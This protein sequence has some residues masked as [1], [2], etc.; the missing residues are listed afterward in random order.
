[1]TIREIR[2]VGDPVLRTPTDPVRQFDKRLRQLAEDMFETMYDAPG[3]GLAANQIGVALRLFVYD[4]G[5]AGEDEDGPEQIGLFCNPRVTMLGGVALSGAAPVEL[6]APDWADGDE[7]CLSVRGLQFVT[8]RWSTATVTGVN[9]FGEPITVT[10]EGLLARCLQHETDHLD[11]KL[12]LDRLVGEQKALAR[13][14][15]AELSRL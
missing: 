14:A 9:V 5:P 2:Q 6:P 12:Y 13:K 4:C 8:P 11:G 1:M 7:G 15:L 10:G 3:V